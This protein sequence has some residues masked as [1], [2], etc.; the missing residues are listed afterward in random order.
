MA[1]IAK[2]LR[3]FAVEVATELSDE[4]AAIAVAVLTDAADEI[5]RLRGLLNDPYYADRALEPLRQNHDGTTPVLLDDWRD[6]IAA[7]YWGT[8]VALLAAAT[9]KEDDR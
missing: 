6:A 2:D 7:L 5:E 1:D 8:I 3:R 4:T 9:P